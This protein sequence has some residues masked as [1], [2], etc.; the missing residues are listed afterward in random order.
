MAKSISKQF[1]DFVDASPAESNKPMSQSEVATA[2]ARKKATAVRP[3]RKVQP[4]KASK[5]VVKK[6]ETTMTRPRRSSDTI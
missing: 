1:R 3:L 5:K 2:V 4:K 6:E